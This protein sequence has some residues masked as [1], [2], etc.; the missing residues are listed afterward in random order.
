MTTA[1]LWSVRPDRAG[2]N[3]R[4]EEGRKI[5]F[6]SSLRERRE[7]QFT[8]Y[9]TCSDTNGRDLVLDKEQ[10]QDFDP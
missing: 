8:F 9:L 2:T 7:E 6:F 5:E 1:D 10:V 4:P 3:K